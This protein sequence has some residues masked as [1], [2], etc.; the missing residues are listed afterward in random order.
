MSS[1]FY[2]FSGAFLFSLE[3]KKETT[4]MQIG[5]DKS[6]PFLYDESLSRLTEVEWTTWRLGKE[7]P[8]VWAAC[9]GGFLPPNRH[10]AGFISD[11]IP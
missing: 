8:T 7:K 4:S 3:K 11:E 10:G 6:V 5:I 2:I 9:P 1:S